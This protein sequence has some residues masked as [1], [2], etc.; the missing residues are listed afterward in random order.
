MKQ[1]NKLK[2]ILFSFALGNDCIADLDH[3][4]NDSLLSELAGGKLPARTAGD[5]LA[6]FHRRQI[7]KIKDVLLETAIAIRLAVWKDDN[8]FI[9]SMDS[10]PHKQYSKKMEKI[11]TNYKG[12]EGFDSQNAYD[13]YGV[14][15]LFDLRSG[16]TH[17]CTDAERWIH[18]IFNKVPKRMDRYYRGDSAYGTGEVYQ[19]LDVANVKFTIVLKDNVAS[20]TRKANKHLLAWKK[21]DIEFFG[22]D[23]CE[24][25]MGFYNEKTIGELRVVFLRKRKDESEI[26][27]KQLSLLEKYDPEEHDYQHY[28]I[29][30]NIDI[31]EMN[32]EKIIEFYRGRANCE[33]FIKEQKYNFDFLHF[34]CKRFEANQAWGLI[35]TFAHNMMRFLS[36]CMEQ[37]VKR[38]RGKDDVIRTVIQLGYF[39]KKVRNELINI[40]CQVAV[41]SRGLKL[42]L[43][44]EAKEVLEK[45][46]IK[47]NSMFSMG[48]VFT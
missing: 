24:V 20:P 25:A 16:N 18:Q 34:P 9:L 43:N 6:G 42:Y 38:V 36:L 47:M 28:S 46:M 23:E 26:I 31:S 5:F 21:T 2:T 11:G 41:R 32:N 7:E 33:N 22:S 14:S 3:L 37:K 13:Q 15:Y 45:I 1:I 8:Q 19:A 10:T 39:A 29:I 40:P 12:I 27:E 48:T 44:N 17:S 4:L 35:G 30:T